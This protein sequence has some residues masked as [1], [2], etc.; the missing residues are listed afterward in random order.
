MKRIGKLFNDI[1]NFDNLVIADKKARAGKTKKY[2][3]I[4]FDK[5]S[6]DNLV[7]LQKALLED[8]YRTSRYHV[9]TIV[10]DRGN[11]EREIFRLPYYPDR[12]VH[13]AIMNVI[14]PYLVKRFTADVFNCIK[15]RGIHYG[16][17]RIKRDLKADKE[18]TKYCLK[19]DIKKFYPS[20]NQDILMNQ[21]SKV[22][23]DKRLLHLLEH[24]IYSVPSGL[25]IGN[26]ISQYAANLYLTW[27]DRWLKQDLK[28][29]HYY[30]YCDDIVI[31]DSD[32]KQLRDY[33]NKIRE[34]L[35]VNLK[36]KIKD[37]WQIF[38]VES[39]G[40]D[41]VGYVFYHEYVLLRKDIKKRLICRIKY[42]GINRRLK[43]LASY[44]GWCKYGNCHNLWYSLT[45]SHSYKRY[46]NNLLRN[47]RIKE[48]SR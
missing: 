47:D 37:N 18:G 27:F 16:V 28:V 46:K 14:E 5:N 17:K 6:H 10:A 12:I 36:L 35:N 9:F 13:H 38:P 33:L 21:F 34:Y 23:K 30:R 11:K 29:K 22:F 8:T 15:K 1:V 45:N 2:G 32:K 24:I 19:I 4:R 40:L 31:L 41:F 26:Y 25:P 39:R 44:W 48:N 20:V 42:K 7:K 3:V 43:S